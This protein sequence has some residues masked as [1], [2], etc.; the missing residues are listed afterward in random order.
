MIGAPAEFVVADAYLKGITKFDAAGAYAQLKSAALDPVAPAGGRG[1][2][3][4]VESYMKYGYVPSAEGGSV[5]W[6]TEYARGDF[7]LAE[8]AQALGQTA[9]ADALHKRAHSY[10]P[11][12]DGTVGFLRGRA[13]DG[14]FPWQGYDSTAY[15]MDYVEANGWQSLWMNDHDPAG[16]IALLGGAQPYLDKLT[17]MF[18]QT[19]MEYEAQDKSN[20]TWGADRPSY[21]WQGNEPDI[22]AP[23]LFNPVG[24]PELT[25]RWV[26]FVMQSQYSDQP[27]GLPGNDDGGATSAWYVFSALGL[28]PIVGS[29]RYELSIPQ[30]P[31]IELQLGGGIFTIEAVTESGDPATALLQSGYVQRVTL[32]GQ[33]VPK[34]ELHH[35]DLQ[36][37]STLRFVIGPDPIS[38]G[39]N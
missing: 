31:K 23:Y 38:W 39:Q 17:Q 32:D 12:Y 7:A 14:S 37:G 4:H 29:D 36:P 16:L 5:S 6:T 3:D 21:Y 1:G 18:E 27:N 25:Q 20:P 9:D 8:L 33:P 19:R 10:A 28:Y 11:L 2:R 26:R 22:H 35:R 13:A 15:T 34:P 30:F 24:H